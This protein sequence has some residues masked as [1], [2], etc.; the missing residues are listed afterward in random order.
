MNNIIITEDTVSGYKHR[1][2]KNASADVT[3][4][5]AADFNTAG[6][7]LT[8]KSVKEQGKLFIP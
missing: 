4:A 3:I 6:E 8:K 2:M 5:I 1:T 7:K